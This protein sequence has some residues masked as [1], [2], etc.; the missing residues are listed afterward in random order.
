VGIRRAFVQDHIA[1][2]ETPTAGYTLLGADLSWRFKMARSEGELFVHG[3]NLT[4]S[5]AR[6]STSF[7]KDIAPLPG[8]N[9]TTG[10]RL[11]F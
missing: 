1:P 11:A 10:V 3:T 6:V 2:G 9:F 7:L 4:D 8:R 5:E